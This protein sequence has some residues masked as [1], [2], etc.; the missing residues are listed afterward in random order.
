ML[1]NYIKE[2]RIGNILVKNNIFLAPMAGVTDIPFRKICRK[3]G[4]GLT[5]TEMASTKA[6]EFNSQKTSK[7][8]HIMDDERPSVVQI[9]GSDKDVIRNTIEKLNDD[10]NIDIIDINMGCPAPKLVK[11][12]DGAGLLLNLDKVEEIIKEATRVSKKPI[13]VK[14]RKGFNDSIIT[15]VKVAKICEKYGVAM[16]TV[17]GRTREQ[18]YSGSADLDIIKAVK[19][20][21]SIPVIGNGDIVDIESAKRMFEYTKCDGIMIA[22]GAQ[23]NPWI[24]KSILKG[25]DYIPTNKERLEIILEHI[26]YA[27]ENEES[28]R[29]ATLKMRKH[30][31]WYLKG[32]KNSSYIKD[33]IN[34]EEDIEKVKEILIEY[35][36]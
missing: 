7:L 15:A 31:A 14:T 29:Q 27:I 19:E 25:K 10:D 33:M 24:F 5:F 20:A 22:R 35:L 16:I 9:F 4:P 23:G 13:T 18:Y 36:L 30:I 26:N 28:I 32:L 34:R 11:N 12:G 21:V 3:F 2:I 17:H 8:L 6:M 1:E